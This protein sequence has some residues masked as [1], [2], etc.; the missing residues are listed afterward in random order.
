MLIELLQIMAGNPPQ[1][2]K[3]TWFFGWKFNRELLTS[4]EGDKYTEGDI[5]SIRYLQ[6]EITGLEVELRKEKKKNEQL[7]AELA[8]AQQGQPA[9]PDNVIRFPTPSRKLIDSA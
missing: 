2:A 5:R 4:P 6:N 9:M 7:A 3:Q 1:Q 8:Q